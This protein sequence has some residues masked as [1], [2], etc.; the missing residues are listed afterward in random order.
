MNLLRNALAFH[1][2]KQLWKIPDL[3]ICRDLAVF[4]EDSAIL[5]VEW[6]SPQIQA[7][8]Q[9]RDELIQS[10]AG[11]RGQRITL[12]KTDCGCV[13]VVDVSPIGSNPFEIG[14]KGAG[15]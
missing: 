9:L 3:E 11:I 5:Q 13:A 6:A 14:L 12:G 2:L 8:S 10:S 4:E 1:A 7:A 15:L